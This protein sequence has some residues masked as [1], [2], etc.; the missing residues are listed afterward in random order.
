MPKRPM[1]QDTEGLGVKMERRK[2]IAAVYV[3]STGASANG[4]PK[5]SP[6]AIG[7]IVADL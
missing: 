1:T 4:A 6:A 2:K 5:G 7:S 3:P